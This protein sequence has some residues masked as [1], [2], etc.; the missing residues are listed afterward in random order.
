MSPLPLRYPAVKGQKIHCG[1]KN[2]ITCA[3]G[4]TTGRKMKR[5]PVSQS[6][7]VTETSAAWGLDENGQSLY[8][9]RPRGRE[10]V[11]CPALTF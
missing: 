6:V 8:T 2:N 1:R 10:T 5:E 7:E 11:T 3:M 4:V 9:F